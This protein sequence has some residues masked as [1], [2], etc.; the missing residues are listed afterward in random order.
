[1]EDKNVTV[2]DGYITMHDGVRLFFQ[3]TGNGDKTLLILNGFFLFNEFAYLAD[4][5]TVIGI[6]LRN[7]GRSDYITDEAK[8]QR[9]IQ[10]DVDDIEVVRRY[11]GVDSIDLLAHSYAALIP[12]L[13]AIKYPSKVGRIVQI[14]SMQPRQS[15]TY[16]PHLTNADSVLQTFFAS[17]GRLQQEQQTLTPEEFCGKFWTLLR[18][19]YVFNPDDA[20]KIEHWKGCHVITELNAMRYWMS[21]LMPSIQGLNFTSEDLA[22]VQCPVLAV[23]GTKDRSGPYGGG[24]EWAL[25]LPN[26]RLLTIENVAHAPWIEAPEKVLGPIRTFLNGAWPDGAETVTSL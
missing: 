19:L 7:R 14:S 4:D 9:G 20:D 12:I 15:T 1:M 21:S 16:P 5:R 17:F 10:Q 25:I 18:T 24:R 26:A 13:Y 8:L 22:K 11:F 6:D 23:H 3:R 2:T